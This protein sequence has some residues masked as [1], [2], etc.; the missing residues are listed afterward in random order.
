MQ[1]VD[2]SS[3]YFY[4]LG[5]TPPPLST[6]SSAYRLIHYKMTGREDLPRTPGNQSNGQEQESPV[7]QRVRRMNEAVAPRRNAARDVLAPSP[8]PI[9]KSVIKRGPAAHG[10][11]KANSSHRSL[12]VPG[13]ITWATDVAWLCGLGDGAQRNA[14]ELSEADTILAGAKIVYFVTNDINPEDL[15]ALTTKLMPIEED[16]LLWR[17]AITDFGAKKSKW[18]NSVMSYVEATVGK[19]MATW[20]EGPENRGKD[21]STLSEDDRLAIWRAEYRR[22]PRA[23]AQEWWKSVGGSLNWDAI[24]AISDRASAEDKAKVNR[25][26]KMLRVK[27]TFACEQVCQYAILGAEHPLPGFFDDDTPAEQMSVVSF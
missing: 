25:V 4:R 23:I 20:S 27:W 17:K 8:S 6:F 10:V 12:L 26:K 5:F 21:F 19:L 13:S 2:Y 18:Q 14:K 15:K 16:S 1:P 24:F 11:K 22:D 9:S 3:L 7:V